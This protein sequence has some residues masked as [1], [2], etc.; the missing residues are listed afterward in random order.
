MVD[1]NEP[2][3]WIVI[4]L[5]DINERLVRKGK[6]GQ[7]CKIFAFSPDDCLGA[8]FHVANSSVTKPPTR[9]GHTPETGEKQTHQVNQCRKLT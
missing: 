7:N 3:G 6:S 5:K 4:P 1:L 9:K 2:A 8:D